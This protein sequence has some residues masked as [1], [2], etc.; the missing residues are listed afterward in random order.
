MKKALFHILALLG[1]IYLAFVVGLEV[2]SIHTFF[3]IDPAILD[4]LQFVKLYAGYGLVALSLLTFYW[5]KGL[6]VILLIL[7]ILVIAVG[8]IAFFFPDLITKVFA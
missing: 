2:N 3:T 6:K 4:K 8:V 5:G 7:T 1:L